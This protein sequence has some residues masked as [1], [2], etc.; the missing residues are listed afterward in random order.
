MM[1][2]PMIYFLGD[3][4]TPPKMFTTIFAI[5]FLMIYILHCWSYVPIVTKIMAF[6]LPK[7]RVVLSL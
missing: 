1:H 4:Y 2:F 6:Y 7:Y 3:V 5:G